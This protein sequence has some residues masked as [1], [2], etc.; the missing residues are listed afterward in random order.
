MI[1]P[2]TIHK[3]KIHLNQF[4][5]KLLQFNQSLICAK[6]CLDK[7]GWIQKCWNHTYNFDYQCNVLKSVMQQNSLSENFKF[8]GESS[9]KLCNFKIKCLDEMENYTDP[10]DWCTI[11][12]NLKIMLNFVLFKNQ[13]QLHILN[14]NNLL[15]NWITR[16][17]VIKN[18]KGGYILL[19]IIW[20]WAIVMSKDIYCGEKIRE[21]FTFL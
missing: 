12:N 5:H 9:W 11:N 6:Q 8:L 14:K 16:S 18:I 2:S 19:I 17:W 13:T 4:I 3:Q 15:I 10:L 7:Y 21:K 1:A 20:M